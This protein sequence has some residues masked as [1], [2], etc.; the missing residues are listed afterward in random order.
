RQ[1]NTTVNMVEVSGVDL[2]R[3]ELRLANGGGRVGYD[4]LVLATGAEQSYFGREELARWAPG[5]KTLQE[6]T[7]VRA[8]ILSAFERAERESE[9]IDR[10]GLLT[11]VLVGAGPTGVEMAGAI[12][13]LRRFTLRHEFRHI[14]PQSA[15]VI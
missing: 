13:E 7:A 5:M 2:A 9:A 15:R 10:R 4:V 11:F 8:R 1:S 6:A 3:R 12:A 14:D